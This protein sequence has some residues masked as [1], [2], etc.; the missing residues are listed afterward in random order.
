MEYRLVLDIVNEVSYVFLELVF[1][2]VREGLDKF[3]FDV[4][5]QYKLISDI[6]G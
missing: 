6:V 2:R 4:N 3:V 1:W 5:E